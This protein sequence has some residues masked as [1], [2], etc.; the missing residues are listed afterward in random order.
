[1][2]RFGKLRAGLLQSLL[3]SFVLTGVTLISTTPESL[4]QPIKYDG[5]KEYIT[6]SLEHAFSS[7]LPAV[8]NMTAFNFTG[9][10]PVV[11]HKVGTPGFMTW[12]QISDAKNAGF[13]IMSHTETH[14]VFSSTTP[15]STVHYEV[16]QS[17]IDLQNHGFNVTGFGP[18]N[19]VFTPYA[20]QLMDAN[21][22]WTRIEPAKPNTLYS[23]TH[24]GL[25]YG[26]PLA[27]HHYG[28][29]NPPATLNNFTQIKNIIDS[30]VQHHT[31][32]VFDFHQLDNTGIGY[33]SSPQLFWKVL[34]YIKQKH[35]AAQI[36]VGSIDDGLAK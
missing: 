35:A 20:K 31:W 19:D 9:E 21:Y 2:V 10:I 25:R 28:V 11:V 26:M 32:V 7:L 27:E 8:K 3:V 4:A 24:D 12:T 14:L 30:A 1:M 17:K 15:N 16:V 34:K 36:L 23:L 22:G 29:G 6:V 13:G 5:T 33:H 18:A